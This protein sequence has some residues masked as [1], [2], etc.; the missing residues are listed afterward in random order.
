MT[1]GNTMTL[2]VRRDRPKR[3]CMC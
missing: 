1:S 2:L 3:R